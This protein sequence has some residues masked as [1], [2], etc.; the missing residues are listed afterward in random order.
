MCHYQICNKCLK[1]LLVQENP[2][3]GNERKHPTAFQAGT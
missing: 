2:N 1:K 3:K